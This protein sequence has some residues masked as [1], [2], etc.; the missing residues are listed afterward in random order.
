MNVSRDLQHM[1]ELQNNEKDAMDL[2]SP[3]F[4]SARIQIYITNN[5]SLHL[6]LTGFHVVSIAIR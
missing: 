5:I 1:H 4:C 2:S 6:Q 3:C